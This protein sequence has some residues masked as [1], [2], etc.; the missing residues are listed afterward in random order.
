[1]SRKT[2]ALAMSLIYR[3]PR[4]AWIKPGAPA[5]DCKSECVIESITPR[6]SVIVR[7]CGD[8]ARRLIHHEAVQMALAAGFLRPRNAIHL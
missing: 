1:M 6:G 4:P 3:S 2:K 8:G 5:S 7:H